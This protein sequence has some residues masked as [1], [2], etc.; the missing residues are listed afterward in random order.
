MVPWHR[1][2]MAQTEE[3]LGEPFLY[4]DWTEHKGVLDLCDM[5]VDGTAGYDPLFFPH[6]YV[7]SSGPTSNNSNNFVVVMSHS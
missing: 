3:E 7:D 5:V 2:Y 1:L 4:W 6:S